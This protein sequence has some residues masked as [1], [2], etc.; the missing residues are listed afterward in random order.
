MTKI[1]FSIEAEDNGEV[2]YKIT[3]L[4]LLPH[5]GN[6]VNLGMDESLD[7]L[8]V[9]EVEYSLAKDYFDVKLVASELVLKSFSKHTVSRFWESLRLALAKN[10]WTTDFSKVLEALE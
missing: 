7:E 10:D 1:I 9:A 5:I 8:E 4:T 3:K 2:F 6:S